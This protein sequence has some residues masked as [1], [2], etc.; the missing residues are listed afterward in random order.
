[1]LKIMNVQ[2][3]GSGATVSLKKSTLQPQQSARLRVTLNK[4]TLNKQ[5]NQIKVLLITNNPNQPKTEININY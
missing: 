2:V 3:I 1:M 4:K 5:E